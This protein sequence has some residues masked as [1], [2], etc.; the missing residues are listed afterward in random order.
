[1]STSVE[2]L[3]PPG[4][5][6][7]ETILAIHFRLHDSDRLARHLPPPLEPIRIGEAALYVVEAVV[8]NTADPAFASALPVQMGFREANLVIPC[9]SGSTLGTY[10]IRTW[11]DRDWIYQFARLF[12]Y[13]G[14]YARI[15]L[16]RFP[17][18]LATLTAPTPGRRLVGG[19]QEIG[20]DLWRAAIRLTSPGGPDLLPWPYLGSVFGY[21]HIESSFRG[22]EGKILAHDVTHE[23]H[24]AEAIDSIWQ[25]DP[26]LDLR[27]APNLVELL[28][29][30]S[31]TGG[32]YFELGLE[33]GIPSIVHSALS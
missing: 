15:G 22:E 12:G 19:V 26:E 11:Y 8:N 13:N 1:M 21:R 5:Y 17:P 30:Y 2:P 32:Y 14:L 7:G 20:G 25:G 23:T 9:Q 27:C 3:V 10:F 18:P 28:G 24:L 4:F 16:T 31:L 6:V 33:L 29:S